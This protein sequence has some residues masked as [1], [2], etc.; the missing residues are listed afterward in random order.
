MSTIIDIYNGLL[1]YDD[2]DI[3]IVIDENVMLWFYAKQITKILNYKN[4]SNIINRFVNHT[5]KTTYDNIKQFSKYKYN[6]QDHAIF[7]NEAGLY[8]L[9]LSSKK[10]IAKKFKDWIVS[11]V[12]P[13]IRKMGKYELNKD[14]KSEIKKLND[15]L[16]K[17]KQKVKILENNQKKEKYPK[18][19]YI[20]IIKPPHINNDLH[21][22]GKTDKNLNKRLNTYNTSLPDKVVVIDKIKVKSP[23]AV[24]LC[25]K[26][27]LHKYRYRNNKEYF[28]LSAKKIMKVI[29]WCNQMLINEDKV[30]GRSLTEIKQL[31]NDKVYAIMAITKKQ[32][33]EYTK[34]QKGGN[35]MSIANTKYKCNK[36]QYFDLIH[37]YHGMIQ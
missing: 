30:L 31:N 18:G 28:K 1:T 36:R 25:V 4:S 2:K 9:T 5:N 7:I 27:F 32:A 12:I 6:V 13:S 16:D 10:K 11:S 34:K 33:K 17:Y 3:V 24:E 20:Y 35:N 22:V 15:K 29:R 19:G 37:Y 21:K 26:S 14:M 23:I 8:E